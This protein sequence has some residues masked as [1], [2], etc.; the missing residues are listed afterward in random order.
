M[1]NQTF[2]KW[3]WWWFLLIHECGEDYN[4]LNVF[5][6]CRKHIIMFLVNL[7]H[8]DSVHPLF[9]IVVQRVIFPFLVGLVLVPMMIFIGASCRDLHSSNISSS[10]SVVGWFKF[11]G[12][13]FEAEC[14]LQME[15]DSLKYVRYIASIIQYFSW[16]IRSGFPLPIW[17]FHDITSFTTKYFYP[18]PLPQRRCYGP[19]IY[20]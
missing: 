18:S 20:S 16:N 19:R 14:H 6:W 10:C 15:A 17:V 13:N 7:I 8:S 9:Y 11:L 4:R 12:D 5:C 1:C 2:G 3:C